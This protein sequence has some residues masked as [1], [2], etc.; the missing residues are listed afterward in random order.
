MD[1]APNAFGQDTA[2][3]ERSRL[4]RL[5]SAAS[6][7]VATLL[8][9]GKTLA[10]WQSGS[11]AMLASL[12]DTAL[13]LI[14]SGVTLVAVLTALNPPDDDHRFGH[15]KAEALAGLFQAAIMIG[16]AAFLMLES[17]SRFGTPPPAAEAG[18]LVILVSGAA[19]V[20]TLALVLFQTFVV[21]RSGSLAIAGDRIHYLGDL[22]MNAGVL[23][24]GYMLTIGM[25][26]ADA[27]IGALIAAYIFFGAWHVLKPAIDMLMDREFS[28]PERE[29]VFELVMSHPDVRG[30]HALKT[31]R[32]GGDQFIQ[33][34]VE[35]DAE[36]TVGGAQVIVRELEA[37][38]SEQFDRAEIL[39]HMHPVSPTSH[40]LTQSTLNH[41]SEMEDKR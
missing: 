13:D 39:I 38:I 35:L 31:R 10:W 21:R 17:I 5:A 26:E 41:R 11:V 24:S 27:V 16:A 34:H 23:V 18:D 25:G 19:I 32:A 30:M 1:Q 36:L 2:E 20:L 8:L 29:L 4:M 3:L 14:T 22:L 7:L 37:Q 28:N 9:A 15:G 33:M 12:G 6:V 40:Q